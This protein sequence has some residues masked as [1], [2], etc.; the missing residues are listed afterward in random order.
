[1]KKNLLLIFANFFLIYANAQ[2]KEEFKFLAQLGHSSAVTCIA[3]DPTGN[4]LASGGADK[5]IKLWDIKRRKLVKVLVG[6]TGRVNSLTF[7]S[8]GD[9]LVSGGGSLSAAPDQYNQGMETIIWDIS[10]D[11]ILNIDKIEKG[12]NYNGVQYVDIN[13]NNS[14]VANVYNNRNSENIKVFDRYK[15]QSIWLKN[16]VGITKTKFTPDG[17]HII[18]S[19]DKIIQVWNTLA[20]DS[21]T[22]YNSSDKLIDFEIHSNGNIFFCTNQEVYLWNFQTG[23]IEN[24]FKLDDSDDKIIELEIHP[25]EK[26]LLIRANQIIFLNIDSFTVNESKST[27]KPY[28]GGWHATRKWTE[29]K[30]N[31]NGDIILFG[32]N[33]CIKGLFPENNSIEIVFGIDDSKYAPGYTGLSGGEGNIEDVSPNIY[34][35]ELS[36]GKRYLIRWTGKDKYYEGWTEKLEVW[37]LKEGKIIK[38]FSSINAQMSGNGKYLLVD[39]VLFQLSNWEKKEIPILSRKVTEKYAKIIANRK[40]KTIDFN[41][42]VFFSPDSKYLYTVSENNLAVINLETRVAHTVFQNHILQQHNLTS[43]ESLLKEAVFSIDGNHIICLYQRLDSYLIAIWDVKNEKIIKEYKNIPVMKNLKISP[44]M[45]FIVG[46]GKKKSNNSFRFSTDTYLVIINAES[47]NV[48]EVK[49]NPGIA[50]LQFDPNS[51]FLLIEQRF[52]GNANT[53]RG[54]FLNIWNLT[55][56]SLAWRTKHFVTDKGDFMLSQI[57]PDGRYVLSGSIDNDYDVKFFDIASGKLSH[58]FQSHTEPL[59]AAQFSEDNQWLLTSAKDFKT[60]LWDYNTRKEL[61]NLASFGE[62]GYFISNHEGYYMF[63]KD[64]SKKVGIS[65]NKFAYDFDQFDIIYNR[66]D[67]VLKSLGLASEETIRIYYSA[68]QKRLGKF[69][70]NENLLKFDESLPEVKILTKN[71]PLATQSKTISLSLLV[72]DKKYPLQRLNLWVNDVPLYGRDGINL[73]S[74]SGKSIQKT[75]DIPLSSGNNKI[76]ISGTN[77]KGL[78]SIKET[79]N[80]TKTSSSEPNIYIVGLGISNYQNANLNLKFATKDIED[81]ISLFGVKKNTITHKIIDEQVNKDRI[82]AI[83]DLLQQTNVDDKVILFFAGHGFLDQDLNYFLGTYEV[84]PQNPSAHGLPYE[85]FEA[86]LD[87]IPARQ[88]LILIDACHSGEVDKEDTEL[89]ALADSSTTRGIRAYQR[90]VKPVNKEPALG[91]QNSFLL[92]KE[93]FADVRRGTGATVLSSAGGAE[94]AYEGME[95]QNGAFTYCLLH[96]LQKWKAD[97]NQDKK[98]T[99]TELQQYV[100]KEVM[101]QTEGKQQPTFRIENITNDWVVWE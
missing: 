88:K 89:V 57:T 18:G 29:I 75:V 87:G 73:K 38:E 84:D 54:T 98:I 6:H 76:Q 47:G 65:N 10:S 64:L 52:I 80:I 1:M 60:I 82:K 97:S 62:D 5:V 46:V 61:F 4:Y 77:E 81:L 8:T 14:H 44:D 53:E 3:V 12:G 2:D 55:D 95:W 26:E 86:L 42:Q 34:Y 45:K 25:S 50:H 94:Y 19:S 69:G 43:S 93:L 23:Q 36:E 24:S 7:S 28:N 71:I 17:K 56:D 59:T 27:I 9:L 79:I 31:N 72:A 16:S 83:K 48:K 39:N 99:I 51:K 78:E 101:Q 96:G 21:V 70:V 33:N 15:K 68:F 74:T 30:F 49:A 35:N 90:G 63:D 58:T 41:N 66:P 92:M 91:L 37:D 40:N 13:S 67:L 85:Q 22:S 100:A 11:K 20:W 32:D